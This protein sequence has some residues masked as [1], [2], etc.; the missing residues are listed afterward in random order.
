MQLRIPPIGLLLVV[1]LF[2]FEACH[3]PV[4]PKPRGYFRINFPKKS[5][6]KFQ[7]PGYPY[8]FEYPTYATIERDTSFFGGKP[9]NPW[10]IDIVF[11]DFDG[12]IYLSYKKIGQKYSLNRLVNDAYKMTYENSLKADNI[13]REAFQ[14]PNNVTGLMYKVSGNAATARQF[15]ATDSVRHFLRGALYFYATPNADSIAPVVSFIEKDMWHLL[16]TLKWKMPEKK[17]K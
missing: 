2:S 3:S 6:R 1:M 9:E 12:K 11:P 15:F 14:T 4:N 5:Y 10:W 8:T 16:K 13:V 7:K 17:M